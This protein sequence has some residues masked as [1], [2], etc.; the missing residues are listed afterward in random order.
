MRGKA[1]RVLESSLERPCVTALLVQQDVLQQLLEH[2]IGAAEVSLWHPLQ[3]V[4]V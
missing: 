3:Q 4:Q 1:C 2:R